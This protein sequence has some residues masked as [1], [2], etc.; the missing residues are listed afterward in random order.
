MDSIDEGLSLHRGYNIQYMVVAQ[1]FNQLKD[2]FGEEIANNILANCKLKMMWGAAT[3][4]EAEMISEMCGQRTVAFE[5]TNVSKSQSAGDGRSKTVSES[6]QEQA[7]DLVSPDEVARISVDWSFVFT[8]GEPPLLVQRPNYVT[9]DEIFDGLHDPHPEY[10]TAEEFE[11]ARKNRIDLGIETPAEDGNQHD[12]SLPSSS[13]DAVP[14]QTTISDNHDVE[15][16]QKT[17]LED[18]DDSL[19]NQMDSSMQENMSP[20]HSGS[21]SDPRERSVSTDESPTDPTPHVESTLDD[22][23]ETAQN[24]KTQEKTQERA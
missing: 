21:F 13:G 17:S 10:S 19:M 12:S 7:R 24:M 14:Q 15:E 18:H 5:T 22:D 4:D 1:S 23:Q 9:D 20:D 11:D 3:R 16:S 6:I 2:S 8:R